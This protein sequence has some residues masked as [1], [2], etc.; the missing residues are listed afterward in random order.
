M[1]YV[2]ARHLQLGCQQIEKLQFNVCSSC[3]LRLSHAFHP[4]H[5]RLP[6]YPLFYAECNGRIPDHDLIMSSKS[7]DATDAFARFTAL[8]QGA[9]VQRF[10]L[11]ASTPT[12]SPSNLVLSLPTAAA[13]AADSNYLGET[14]GRVSN[15]I[16]GAALHSV[17]GRSWPLHAN[18]PDGPA[19]LH[20]G[21]RGWGKAAF[22][23]PRAVQRAGRAAQQWTHVS[24][25]GDE[26]FPGAVQL[27]VWYTPEVVLEGG[28]EVTRLGIE[29]EA[30]LVGEEVEETVVAVTNHTCVVPLRFAS[31]RRATG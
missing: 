14:I 23:G 11:T 30:R 27:S 9:L 21:A 13:Y 19:T 28:R 22:A 4:N 2:Y 3:L 18:E 17:A 8:T 6:N 5:L 25:H 24:A 31:P 16:G 29:Y 7:Q 12:T 26:G 10:T 1:T 20:G 15:R